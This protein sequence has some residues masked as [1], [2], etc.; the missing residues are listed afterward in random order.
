[1]TDQCIAPQVM[2]AELFQNKTP[3]LVLAVVIRLLPETQRRGALNPLPLSLSLSLSLSQG[4]SSREFW[5]GQ[6][7]I[8][9]DSEDGAQ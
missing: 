9:F 4:N 5:E 6:P 7:H 1:M 2:T 3:P 8:S